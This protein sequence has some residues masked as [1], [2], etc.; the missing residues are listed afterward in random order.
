[1]SVAEEPTHYYICEGCFL[2]V[3]PALTH[4][5]YLRARDE[6]GRF[7]CE[8]CLHKRLSDGA[9]PKRAETH[10]RATRRGGA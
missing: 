9:K 7:L 8:H 4:R 10:P 5:Q 1:M 2:D 6:R 3:E